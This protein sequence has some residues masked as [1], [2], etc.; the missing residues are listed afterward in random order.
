MAQFR[1]KPEAQPIQPRLLQNDR[2][3]P[4]QI[5]SIKNSDTLA[6]VRALPSNRGSIRKVS[7]APTSSPASVVHIQDVHLNPE[8]QTNIAEVIKDVAAEG[9]I[10]LLAVEGAFGSVDLSSLNSYPYPDSIKKA[11]D[12]LFAQ[13]KIGGPMWAAITANSTLPTFLGVDDPVLYQKNVEAYQ[14]AVGQ[15]ASLLAQLDQKSPLLKEKSRPI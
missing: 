3:L 11:A 12:Y 13:K 9:Q 10:D 4:L 6:L 15:Q 8:A 1:T 7:I 2:L 14:Q 5:R